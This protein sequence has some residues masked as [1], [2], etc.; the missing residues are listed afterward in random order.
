[1]VAPP[2]PATRKSLTPT[3]FLMA[4][5]RYRDHPRFAWLVLSYFPNSTPVNSSITVN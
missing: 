5:E 1:V 2:P 3:P 4:T